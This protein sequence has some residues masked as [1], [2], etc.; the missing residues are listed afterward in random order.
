VVLDVHMPGLNGLDVQSRLDMRWPDIPVIIITGHHSPDTQK[1][2]MVANP[3][4]YLQKPM[5][6]Q[7]LLNAIDAALQ[8]RAAAAH[9]AGALDKATD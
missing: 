3:V 2:A 8:R 7:L 1:R 5:S 9:R 6:D 4:A